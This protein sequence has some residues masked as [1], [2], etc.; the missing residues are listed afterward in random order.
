M[1]TGKVRD[2]ET[3]EA[4]GN[5]YFGAR[6]Y[7]SFT[8]RFTSADWSNIPEAVPYSDLRY[9]Q[10]LNLY[11]YVGNN[12][13]SA[14]DPD[15]HIDNPLW[16]NISL[17]YNNPLA[18][19]WYRQAQRQQDKAAQQKTSRGES[20]V[21]KNIAQR[22]VA[23]GYYVSP[24]CSSNN[25]NCTYTLTGPNATKMYVYEHQTQPKITG[26]TKVG[27]NDYV[28]PGFNGVKANT[29]AFG[30]DELA[31]HL[32][33]YR[34]F[35]ISSKELY[36]DSD[37]Q[38]VVIHENGKISGFEHIFSSGPLKPVEINGVKSDLHE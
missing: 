14:N 28:S 33:T 19:Q 27:E 5:D 29:G 36:D 20:A 37:Q 32:D 16:P 2:I 31:G 22:P 24:S 4:N 34:Y 7:G 38:Y 11:T 25:N 17:M 35:T 12:P 1:Y 21:R 9:P 13:L 26:T 3:G 8:G 15:G 23:N 18:A 10:T 30:L 6:Y